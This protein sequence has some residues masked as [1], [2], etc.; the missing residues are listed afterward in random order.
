[1]RVEDKACPCEFDFELLEKQA[2]SKEWRS[3][4]PRISLAGVR[5]VIRKRDKPFNVTVGTGLEGH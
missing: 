4:M 3:G 2:R 5:K 1:M